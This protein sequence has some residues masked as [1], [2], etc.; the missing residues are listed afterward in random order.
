MC[1][2]KVSNYTRNIA[3]ANITNEGTARE[4]LT[5]F[6]Q[7]SNMIDIFI[8]IMMCG[9]FL[10]RVAKLWKWLGMGC[11]EIVTQSLLALLSIFVKEF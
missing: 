11:A 6:S 10:G 2:A 1:I 3:E 7:S 5:R 4:S 8:Y 9:N